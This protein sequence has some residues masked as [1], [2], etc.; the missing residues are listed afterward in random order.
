MKTSLAVRLLVD[1]YRERFQIDLDRWNWNSMYPTKCQEYLT[2]LRSQADPNKSS[3]GYA[4]TL[5]VR[6]IEK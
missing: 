2:F 3:R 1:E 5:A 4:Y 6:E